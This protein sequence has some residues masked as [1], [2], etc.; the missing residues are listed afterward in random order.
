MLTTHRDNLAQLALNSRLRT[1]TPRT[2]ADF[3]SNDYL[4]LARSERLRA[5]VREAVAE[6]LAIGSGGSRLLR[7]NDPEH[8]VLEAEAA[9]FFQAEAALFFANGYMANVALLSTLPQAGDL[10]VFDEHVHASAHD[11]MRLGRAETARVAHNDA[12]AFETAILAWRRA[13]GTGRPWIAVESLYS[14]DGDMAPLDALAEIA[15]RHD[16]ILLIDEAHATGVFG[17][18]GRGLAERLHACENVV[19]LH[20][21]GKGLGCEG[22]LVCGPAIVRDFLV[23]RGRSFIFTTAPSPLMARAVRASLRILADEPERRTRLQALVQRAETALAGCGIAPTGSQILPLILGDDARTMRV[24]G[25]VQ[26]AGFDVR[27][28]RPP[29]VPPGT[30]RLRISLT[31]NVDATDIAALA[32][33][34]GDAL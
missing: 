24:A 1:L 12:N 21:C 5:A 16:G 22:A 30:S 2:G 11:G 32:R 14:M 26:R 19:T 9:A 17:Q 20:T 8:E 27:G 25:A 28:I 33:A 34:I 7:G 13:G 10:I 3:A 29:T 18:H 31:L 6:G 15:D 4:G 23:N